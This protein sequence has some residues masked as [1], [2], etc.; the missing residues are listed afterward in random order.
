MHYKFE[1]P[2]DMSWEVVC[3]KSSDFLWYLNASL[4]RRLFFPD[5]NISHTDTMKTVHFSYIMQP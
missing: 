3:S 5:M 1:A 2:I 4:L